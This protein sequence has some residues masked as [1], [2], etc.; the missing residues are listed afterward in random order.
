MC[1]VTQCTNIPGLEHRI[2]SKSVVLFATFDFTSVIEGSVRDNE[3]RLSIQC[4]SGTFRL[5]VLAGSSNLGI[6]RR[7]F[8][9]ALHFRYI[10]NSKI[11][12]WYQVDWDPSFRLFLTSKLSNPHYTPE[13][14][15][16][17]LSTE[18]VGSAGCD[19]R[20]SSYLL[21]L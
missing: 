6:K 18:F 1:C 21:V 16:K 15:G 10:C 9:P 2:Y 3:C 14:F 13:V 20:N 17:V 7:V 19:I 12:I 11:V 8:C 5:K 4:L